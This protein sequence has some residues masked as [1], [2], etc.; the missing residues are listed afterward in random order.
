MVGEVRERGGGGGASLFLEVGLQRSVLQ[1]S[2][3]RVSFRP[4]SSLLGG[5][6]GKWNGGEEGRMRFY[7]SFFELLEREGGGSSLF[8]FLF[9]SFSVYEVDINEVIPLLLLKVES[10]VRRE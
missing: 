5:G 10:G 4:S 7:S 1:S 8:I 6:G 3:L 9:F 2:I